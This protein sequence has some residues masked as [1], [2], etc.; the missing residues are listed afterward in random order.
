MALRP[1]KPPSATVII[2]AFNEEKHLGNLLTAISRQSIRNVE[3]IIVDSGS[4]DKTLSI[5]VQHKARILKIK[6]TEFTFGR[7]LNIGMRA[8]RSE[9]VVL[10]SAHVVPSS[11]TWLEKLLAPFKDHKVAL[12]YGK[13]RGGKGTKFSEA[14]HFVRWFADQSDLDQQNAFCNNANAAL[15]RSIWKQ[16]P[17]DEKLTG[18]EDIAWASSARDKGHK[19]AYAADAGIQHL[20]DETAA[21]IVNRHRREALALKQILP[22]SRFT[23]WNFA[24]LFL[25][26]VFSDFGAALRER[27]FLHEVLGIISFRF[28][29]YLGTYRGYRDPVKVSAE[30]RE[31]FFYPP[32][33]LEKRPKPSPKS[34]KEESRKSA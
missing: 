4:T 29:Q 14:R 11:D 9:L 2:R 25:R 10:A 3:V 12:V 15:R 30:M 5:A 24:S 17:F 28:L 7:S 31:V 26:S 6:P 22:K 19:I 32:G 27:V 23:V 8:A 1:P 18:L 16:S 33:S 21:Q 34:Y 20:H 13:Q